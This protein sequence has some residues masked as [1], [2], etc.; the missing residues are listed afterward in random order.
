VGVP[1]PY[2][3][4]AVVPLTHSICKYVVSTAR[5][6]VVADARRHPWLASN[7]AIGELG[8]VAYAGVPIRSEGEVVGAFCVSDGSPREW[9]EEDVR[10][11]GDLAALVEEEVALR[12]LRERIP[13]APSAM[14]ARDALENLLAIAA[15]YEALVEQSIVGICIV[16]GGRFRYVNRRFAEMFGRS[17]EEIL[18]LDDVL[19]LVEEEDRDLVAEN[20]RRRIEGEVPTL[21]YSLRG[22]RGDG[23]TIDVEVHGT[24]VEM[25]GEPAVVSVVLEI[26]SRKRMERALRASQERLRLIVDGAHDA[27]VALDEEGAIVEWN[28]QAERIFGWS[29]EE[30]L[31]RPVVDTILPARYRRAHARA[32]RRLRE[33]GDLSS[34][35]RRME[36]RVRHR[37]GRDFPVELTVTAVPDDG[38]RLL[39]A[40]LH[41]V[42]HRREAEEALR[43][44]EERFRWLLENSWDVIQVLDE[45][46]VIRYAGPSTEKVLGYQG[47]EITGRRFEDLVHPDDRDSVRS[48]LDQ[49]EPEA[50]TAPVDVRVRHREGEYRTLEVRA[51]VLP[52]PDGRPATFVNMHDLTARDGARRELERRS[53]VIDLMRGVATAANEASTA[54]AAVER[55]LSLVC[56]Y[57]GWPLGHATLL[58]D[59]GNPLPDGPWHPAE[60]QLVE[61]LRREVEREI[62][63]DGGLAA[64]VVAAG[65]PVRV[66]A[67]MLVAEPIDALGAPGGG[68]HP[69]RRA[70]DAPAAPP[71][72]TPESAPDTDPHRASYAVPVLAGG[73][74]AAVLEFHHPNT[75]GLDI[76]LIALT[77]DVAAQL[78]RVFEREQA[79]EALR[80]SD[81]RFQLVARATNDVIWEWDVRAGTL[82]WSDIAARVLRYRREEMGNSIDWWYERIH[83]DDR[84]RVVSALHA[85][86]ARTDNTWSGEYRLQRGDG[87]YATVLDRV[88]VVRDDRDA[89]VRVI[90]CML[91]I[92]ERRQ[93]EESQRLLSQATGVLASSLEPKESLS[94]MAQLLVPGLCDHCFIDLLEGDRLRRVAVAHVEPPRDPSVTGTGERELA[95]ESTGGVIARAIRIAEP[96]LVNQPV[97][98]SRRLGRG[99]PEERWIAA[100]RPT[101]LLVVPLVAFGEV[102]GVIVL[103]TSRSRRQYGPRELLLGEELARRCT[104]ALEN[105]R[106]YHQAREAVR[107]R[108]E[109]LGVVSHDLRNPLHTIQLATGMLQDAN[110]ERRA[111]NVRWLNIIERT[112]DGMEHMI[113][114]LLDLSS[115]DAG[116]FSIAPADHEVATIMKM[117]CETFEPLAALDGIEIGCH[118]A[119]EV[120]TVWIDAHR[121]H[122]VFSNLIGNALKFTPYGGAIRLEAALEDEQVRFTVQDSGPGIPVRDLPRVFDRGWQAR[123]GDRR[124]AGL[125]LAIARGI[126]E[127]HQGRIWVESV[128][129]EG[130]AFRFT[131]PVGVGMGE[132]EGEVH[133]ETEMVGG[134]RGGAVGER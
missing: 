96:I 89:A 105:S 4:G 71:L 104:L 77:A 46:G 72:A 35:R 20:L 79:A 24:R 64:R 55:V 126:V 22:R 41:D 15:R 127:Q 18:S 51:Q 114:D 23:A 108:E 66:P 111:E 133:E 14:L 85:S 19:E 116:R 5:P 16:S 109:V 118:V 53:V 110:Q 49:G 124:G 128:P 44:N 47:S 31:G 86:L 32:L 50:I 3:G 69:A 88:W 36:I 29:R 129:G 92:T 54:R 37:D 123:R 75:I 52:D 100:L 76:S 56:R 122:R 132:G 48:A 40:F 117:V 78:G 65:E 30:A 94:R 87:Q 45:D 10:V 58:D 90:G 21:R 9:S 17:Q 60:G 34:M 93:T 43:R 74:I 2:G 91:D 125:G 11:L 63:E 131:V 73:S 67:E 113:E 70:G 83:A 7:R 106:L 25:E 38:R 103:V 112:V 107:A 102:L 82:T 121:I 130:A 61:S 12:R 27:F 62:A 59:A 39:C 115:I 84:E 13:V 95:S 57:C 28:A 98:G 99:Q 8:M 68:A 101:S 119:P 26:T 33:S 120:S 81:E 42:S 97:L 6:L 80:A 1:V 134:V